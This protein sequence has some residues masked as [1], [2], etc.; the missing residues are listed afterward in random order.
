M[1]PSRNLT[2]LASEDDAPSC[3][4]V[5]EGALIFEN[6]QGPKRCLDAD[7]VTFDIAF[8]LIISQLKNHCHI[9]VARYSVM[10]LNSFGRFLRV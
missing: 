7:S 2:D 3:T 10:G 9:S 5:V 6:V 1:S 4:K 8:F